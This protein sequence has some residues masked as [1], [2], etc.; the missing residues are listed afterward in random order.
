MGAGRAIAG[1]AEDGVSVKARATTVGIS[2][3]RLDLTRELNRILIDLMRGQWREDP[4]TQVNSFPRK[5]IR[6]LPPNLS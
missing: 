1:W 5:F 2:N 3:Q 6:I 4:Q